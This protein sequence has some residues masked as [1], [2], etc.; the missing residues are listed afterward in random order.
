MSVSS[1]ALHKNRG[2]RDKLAETMGTREASDKWG[3][4]QA[5]IS[6]WCRNGLIPS[7]SQDRAGSPW[8]IPKDAEC[9]RPIKKKESKMK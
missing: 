2:E 6:E 7:A 4:S 3:Y 5:Y 9:P 1:R 8:H